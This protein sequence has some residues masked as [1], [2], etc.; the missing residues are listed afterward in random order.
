MMR[1]CRR[2]GF[3]LVE[4]L[5]V[6]A[7]IGMLV[8]L[9]LPAVQSARTS[10]RR[11]QCV[12]NLRQIGL[13]TANYASANNHLPPPTA[14]AQFENRGSTLV[15]LLPYLEEGALYANYQL[16]NAITDR[17]NALVTGQSVPVFLCPEMS[18]NRPVPDTECGEVLAAGSYVISSR[19]TY[20]GHGRLDGAFR[21]PVAGRPYTLSYRHITDGTSKTLLFGEVNYGHVEYLWTDCGEKNGSPKWGD[22]TWA[23]GYWFFAWG[24]M[25]ADLPKL[26]NNVDL[27]ASPNSARTFRS[28][29]PGGVHFVFL[30]GSVD[31]LA[32]DSDPA[33]RAA[34]VTRSGQEVTHSSR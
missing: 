26:F 33:V 24:H 29:H 7:V 18:T 32:N 17:Q 19:T 12:N 9:L 34:L 10:A 11:M 23:N 30:D 3:T 21:N 31:M 6:I 25:S 13:A 4:L 16:E 1:K 22:T 20:S 5:V 8:A 15:L 28:D 14:G 2:N 27:F